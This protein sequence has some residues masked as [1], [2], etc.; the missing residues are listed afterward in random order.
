MGDDIARQLNM[1]STRI[2]KFGICTDP[3]AN[4]FR[5]LDIQIRINFILNLKYILKIK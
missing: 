2:W 5:K 3:D 4:A 1:N